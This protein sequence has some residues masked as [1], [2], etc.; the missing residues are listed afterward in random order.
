MSFIAWVGALFRVEGG[1]NRGHNQRLGPAGHLLPGLAILVN[2][3][4]G[5]MGFLDE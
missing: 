2:G 4:Y 1:A 3:V 5:K